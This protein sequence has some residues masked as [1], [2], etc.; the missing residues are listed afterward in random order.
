M[1]GVVILKRS[2]ET[3]RMF[4]VKWANVKAIPQ[5]S[6]ADKGHF[7]FSSTIELLLSQASSHVKLI[8]IQF[9]SFLVSLLVCNSSS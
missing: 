9:V 2:I 5:S 3:V 4:D 1:P 6:F 8:N 7:M